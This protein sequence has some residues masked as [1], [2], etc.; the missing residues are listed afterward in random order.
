MKLQIDNLDGVGPRDYT[1]A[2]DAAN[3]PRITRKLN[4]PSQLRFSLLLGPNL[5]VPRRGSRVLLGRT[6][7]QDVFTG[8]VTADPEYEFLGW[9]QQGPL[10]RFHLVALSDESLLDEKRL[11]ARSPF[12]ARSAGDALRQLTSEAVAGVFDTTAVQ[13]LDALPAYVPDPQLPW[14]KHAKAIATRAR[15]SYRTMNGALFLA[16]L[17]AAGYSVSESDANF[18]PQG[19]TLKPCNRGAEDVTVAGETEPQDYVRDYFVGDGLTTRFHLSQ[20]PFS[21][22]THTIFNE[23]YATPALDPTRWQVTDPAGAVSVVAGKLQVSGGNGAD[24]ATTVNFVEQVELGAAW[25]LQHG[26]FEF[27]GPSSGILGGLYLGTVSATNCIAGFGVVPAGANSQLQALINGIAVGA[28]MTTTPGHHYVLSTRIYSG[29]IFREQQVY[30]GAAHPAG[31]ALG[32]AALGA[33]VRLVLEVHDVDPANPATMVSPS[34]VLYDGVIGGAPG[35]CTYALVNSPALQCAIAF[36]RFIQ[37]IDAEVRSALPGQP[38][39]TRLVGP[40]SAGAE[41]NVYSGP[42]LDFFNRYVP[43]LNEL[44]EVHYRGYG[45]AMARVTNPASISTE[46]RGIDDGVRGAVHHV[47]TPAARTSVDCEN[48]ALAIVSDGAATG[49]AG[50]YQTWSDFLP[51]GAQDVFPGDGLNLSLPSRSASLQAI[52]TEV[53]I[54]VKD[55]LGDH[56]E[57]Q[58]QFVDATDEAL[59]FEFDQTKTAAALSVT[60]ITM[61]QVGSTTLA[62]LT[63]AAITLVSST[64]ASLDAGSAPTPGGGIEVR[65]TD[66]GWGPYN[67]QNLAGRFTT[68]AFTLPRLAKT[69]DY[70]LRQFDGSTPPNYS[71]YSAA[72]HLDY[73]F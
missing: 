47:K 64:T 58:I 63:T 71:R 39:R 20:N 52:V 32:G 69:Q 21:R 73:P 29:T 53:E 30:H 24:G 62:D 19:L 65:W 67:D 57:Y 68:Q 14:S 12:V 38:Y 55:L 33:N 34:T 59:A 4:E 6:N 8:Y 54:A 11:P 27:A 45:R 15:A 31:S 51:G 22:F 23:E 42:I 46:Q 25:L 40:I 35:F 44:V 9:G 13:N 70:Y 7:G 3:T 17:A 50:K 48:A 37:A 72:L 49:L 26:D 10:Y 2:I 41:C 36:T 61:A 43:A 56:S 66:A 28:A 60:P 18:S 1:A 5:V 16:P